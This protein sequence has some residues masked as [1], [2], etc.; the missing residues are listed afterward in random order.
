MKRREILVAL[1]LAP[2]GFAGAVRGADTVITVYKDP[3]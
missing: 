3:G 1:A 2:L